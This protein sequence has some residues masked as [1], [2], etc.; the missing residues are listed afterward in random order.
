M[1]FYGIF[2]I[3]ILIKDG[4]VIVE[5]NRNRKFFI[6]DIV[7]IKKFITIIKIVL[8]IIIIG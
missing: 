6:L 3:I 8:I 2:Y 4:S 5:V 1:K 7:A